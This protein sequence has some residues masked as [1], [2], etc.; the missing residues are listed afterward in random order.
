M[1][2][3]PC[4]LLRADAGGHLGTGHVFRCLAL[5]QAWQDAGGRVVLLGG[6][7]AGL[8]PRLAA[9]GVAVETMASEFGGE[10]DAA[11]TVAMARRVGAAW[12]ALDGYHFGAEYQRRV[13][14]S[15]CRPL[16]VDDYGHAGGY[17]ADL[18]LNQNL[19]ADEATYRRRDDGAELLL[20]LRFAMLRRE[21]EPYQGWTRTVPPRAGSVLVTLGGTDPANVTGK[22]VEA[23]RLLADPTLSALVLVGAGNPRADELREAARGSSTP[24]ELRANVSDM[25]A[26]LARADIAVGAGGTSSWE[27]AFLGLPG[28]VTVLAD[29]Q[30]DLAA[31]CER[32]GLAANLGEHATVTARGLAERL[33]LLVEDGA[34]RA[35]MARRGQALVDGLGA[36]RVV[37]RMGLARA[38]LRRARPDDVRLLWE[39]ANEPD[40]RAVSFNP[41]PIPWESHQGWFAA[42]LRDPDCVLF[43]A[44]DAADWAE[45]PVG[46]VRLDVSGAEATVSVSLSAAARGKGLGREVIATACRKLF[47][48]RP[49][50]G[51]IHAYIRA[52]NE[53]SLRAFAAAGFAGAEP[54]AVHGHAA[55]R[56]A[57]LR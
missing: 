51:A 16:V 39:W 28:L 48:A 56:L 36:G 32:H 7:C 15:G 55:V 31:A 12:V 21:F 24:I 29:N 14:Q 42:R 20:G 10:D 4:L 25:P 9:A 54:A 18:I 47:A 6:G 17:H 22:A 45:Q 13:R 27:R 50:V 1:A 52:D 49:A 41:A 38:L 2:S 34:A 33:R 11:Q 37:A 40:V 19:G 8:L 44:L 57:L 43:V 3:Q 30:R 53:A 5:A 23:L 26:V 35:E 46:Q